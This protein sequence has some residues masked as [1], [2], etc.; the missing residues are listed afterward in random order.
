MRTP[1]VSIGLCAA[2]VLSCAASSDRFAATAS[3]VQIIMALLR[4]LTGLPGN[5][6]NGVF[7]LKNLS[8][9]YE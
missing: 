7:G 2:V 8:L 4:G 9:I 5:N 3:R 1:A 6:Y